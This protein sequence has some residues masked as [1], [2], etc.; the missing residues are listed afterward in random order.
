MPILNVC[1]ERLAELARRKQMLS[2]RIAIQRAELESGFQRLRRPMEVFDKAKAVGAR[3]R[4]HAPAIAMVLGPLLFL[5][6][7][8]LT[9]GAGLATRMVKHATRLWG[10][11]K[12]GSKLFARI[13]RPARRREYAR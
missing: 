9:G 7:R 1:G 13:P 11:W 12:V 10:L 2:Y 5:L 6:R 8:R 4:E 3:L